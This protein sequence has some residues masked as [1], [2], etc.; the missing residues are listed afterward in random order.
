LEWL[1]LSE[2]LAE[3][4]SRSGMAATRADVLRMAVKRGLESLRAE[5]KPLE[6]KVPKR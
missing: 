6:R 2:E 1:E 5:H 3:V 4:I